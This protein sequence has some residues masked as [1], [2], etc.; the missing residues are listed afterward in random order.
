MAGLIVILLSASK[1]A[2]LASSTCVKTIE[3]SVKND[4][5]KAYLYVHKRI[6]IMPAIMKGLKEV[7]CVVPE[8]IHTPTTEGIGNFGGVGGGG[9]SKAQEIPER[10]GVV[11]EI[12]FPYI[13]TSRGLT[14]MHW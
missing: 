14:E 13:E 8:N 10:R 12:T 11:S 9:G 6:I 1:L 7:Y 2:F 5:R 4:A 3:F